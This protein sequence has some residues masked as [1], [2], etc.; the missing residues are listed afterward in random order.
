MIAII[1][2][3]NYSDCNGSYLIELSPSSYVGYELKYAAFHG[4]QYYDEAT[5]AFKVMLSILDDSPDAQSK[6]R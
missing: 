4:A 6:P 1:F 5:E 2:S 3:N